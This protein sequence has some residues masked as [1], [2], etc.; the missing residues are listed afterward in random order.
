[1]VVLAGILFIRPVPNRDSCRPG[2]V[3]AITTTSLYKYKMHHALHVDE[4]LGIIFNDPILRAGGDRHTYQTISPIESVFKKYPLLSLALTCK[5][6]YEPATRA[7]WQQI[8]GLDRLVRTMSGDVTQTF[9][10]Y[11]RR[12]ERN[13]EGKEDEGERS[14]VTERF[15]GQWPKV[16]CIVGPFVARHVHPASPHL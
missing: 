5:T 15:G 13:A 4:I 6:F 10:P 1:M 14:L 8:D 11:A 2:S 16:P 9:V 7:L 3:A 12:K